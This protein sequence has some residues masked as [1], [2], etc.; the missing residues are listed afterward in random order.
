MDRETF[1]NQAKTLRERSAA[2]GHKMTVAE[3]LEQLA[4]G[5]G[6][7]DWNTASAALKRSPET[8]GALRDEQLLDLIGAQSAPPVRPESIDDQDRKHTRSLS[9]LPTVRYLHP[10]NRHSFGD[11]DLAQRIAIHLENILED[12]GEVRSWLAP[13]KED[14]TAQ[15]LIAALQDVEGDGWLACLKPLLTER[16]RWVFLPFEK[17][18]SVFV[19]HEDALARADTKE[20]SIREA[21]Q[22]Q[23]TILGLRF[24]ETRGARPK[25]PAPPA[26]RLSVLKARHAAYPGFP[27]DLPHEGD[28]YA[29]QHA[30]QLDRLEATSLQSQ[31]DRA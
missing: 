8:F 20:L 10:V 28:S 25:H 1:K 31:V 18:T 13:L 7:R 19:A 4:R 26:E 23:Q 16:G 12:L 15:D 22:R 30:R 14:P 9:R 11:A 6:Y 5:Y 29:I 21:I 2:R 3:S 24:P 17:G 27:Y